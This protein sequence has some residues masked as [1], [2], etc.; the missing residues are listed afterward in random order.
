MC[1][2]L[3]APP[4]SFAMK[5]SVSVLPG[6]SALHALSRIPI[7]CSKCIAV[8]V[9]DTQGL[10]AATNEQNSELFSCKEESQSGIVTVSELS[11]Q[12][13]TRVY[14]LGFAR[15][16]SSSPSSLRSATTVS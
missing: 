11:L 9:S 10:L 8:R 7:F 3:S 4:V 2:S 5:F 12:T 6:H 14:V 1:V 16:T 13:L 15:S